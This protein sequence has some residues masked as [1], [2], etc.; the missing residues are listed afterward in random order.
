MPKYYNHTTDELSFQNY[1][2]NDQILFQMYR[3]CNTKTGPNQFFSGKRFKGKLFSEYHNEFFDRNNSSWPYDLQ[4]DTLLILLFGIAGKDKY[5]DSAIEDIFNSISQRMPSERRGQNELL[6]LVLNDL[7]RYAPYDPEVNAVCNYAEFAISNNTFS[8]KQTLPNYDFP[9]PTNEEWYNRDIARNNIQAEF[10]TVKDQLTKN[11]WNFSNEEDLEFLRIL[12]DMRQN[13]PLYGSQIFDDFM[14]EALNTRIYNAVDKDKLYKSVM[15]NLKKTHLDGYEF[16]NDL[17]GFINYI[18]EVNAPQVQAEA[19][20]N[21]QTTD[22]FDIINEINETSNKRGG[23]YQFMGYEEGD[24][25]FYDSAFV[26]E[27]DY[28]KA[29]KVFSDIFGNLINEQKKT[30]L[31]YSEMSELDRITNTFKIIKSGSAEPMDLKAEVRQRLIKAGR[32]QNEDEVGILVEEKRARM[33]AN[34]KA[35]TT[36]AKHYILHELQNP[37]TKI[38]YEAYF[39]DKQ[40]TRNDPVSE[41]LDINHPKIVKARNLE[42]HKLQHNQNV[43]DHFGHEEGMLLEDNY[44][45][46]AMDALQNNQLIPLANPNKIIN[47]ISYA[48]AREQL[49]QNG[50]KFNDSPVEENYLIMLFNSHDPMGKH[51]IEIENCLNMMLQTPIAGYHERNEI[52]RNINAEIKEAREDLTIQALSDYI[53]KDLGL[54]S[55]LE[56]RDKVISAEYTVP[57]NLY[58]TIN[59]YTVQDMKTVMNQNGWEID[60]RIDKLI[61]RLYNAYDPENPYTAPVYEQCINTI[62]NARADLSLDDMT[63][64]YND[65]RGMLGPIKH[66]DDAAWDI[67]EYLFDLTAELYAMKNAEM[68]APLDDVQTAMQYYMKNTSKKKI[69]TNENNAI[70]DING[71]AVNMNEK[72]PE[73]EFE[74]VN[75]EYD[76]YWNKNE[77]A[78]EDNDGNQNIYERPTLHALYDETQKVVIAY[79]EYHYIKQKIFDQLTDTSGKLIMTAKQEGKELGA[80]GSGTPLYREMA[81]KLKDCIS[82]FQNPESKPD[83][84]RRS[85]IEFREASRNY[86]RERKSIFGKR[87]D[88]KTRY[89]ESLKWSGNRV[90]E[91]LSMYDNNLNDLVN[92]GKVVRIQFDPEQMTDKKIAYECGVLCGVKRE[93]DIP[94][95]L[96]GDVEAGYNKIYERAKTYVSVKTKLAGKNHEDPASNVVWQKY[97]EQLID[98]QTSIEELRNLQA[99]I[100]DKTYDKEVS[101]LKNS[102][103]FARILKENPKNYK[104][105]WDTVSKTGAELHY[106]SK[107]YLE[108][109]KSAFAEAADKGAINTDMGLC[110]YVLQED[111][112]LGAEVQTNNPKQPKVTELDLAYKRLAQVVAYQIIASKEDFARGIVVDALNKGKTT[113]EITEML[114]DEV[115]AGLREDKILDGPNFNKE[116]FGRELNNGTVTRKTVIAIDQKKA[117]EAQHKASNQKTKTKQKTNTEG[118]KF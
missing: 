14:S 77:I 36:L 80:E 47:G 62:Q 112:N 48:D 87:G 111:V 79:N 55:Y 52:L 66:N 106:A 35:M 13:N 88:G 60:A 97:N 3:N 83:E 96:E 42:A 19:V 37:E 4:N 44:N 24:K 72:L 33:A 8:I 110:N 9:L 18:R 57:E 81:T 67:D 53:Y 99:K 76:I 63:M 51:H 26:N 15:D 84:I 22:L 31:K 69:T 20:M 74:Y 92:T 78:I 40:Y 65:L 93:V 39:G 90:D 100:K 117:S 25:A 118:K 61:N 17:Q 7:S 49:I 70:E 64:L 12:F 45:A 50:W 105:I 54:T 86:E 107:E 91:M 5:I 89:E 108:A 38:C 104:K 46:T 102:K 11:G 6:E 10:N 34:E 23:I 98:P 71:L 82:T 30:S 101:E 113:N 43:L 59:G 21:E 41:Y 1:I 58:K 85:L 109:T 75:D 95:Q 103:V 56:A 2:Q 115:E 16:T 32:F 94:K 68:C 116:Q 29:D 73:N 28:A 114:R 27:F